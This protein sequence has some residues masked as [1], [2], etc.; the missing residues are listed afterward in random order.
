ML[1]ALGL[2]LFGLGKASLW[3]DEAFSVFLSGMSL[4]Q[5]TYRTGLDVHPPFYYYLLKVWRFVSGSSVWNLRLMSVFFSLASLILVYFLAR[6]LKLKYGLI[7]A[8]LTAISLA[9]FQIQYAQE[10]RMYSLGLFLVL[11][12]VYLLIRLL[13]NFSWPILT[14]YAITIALACYTHYYLFFLIAAQGLIVLIWRRWKILLSY[15]LAGLIF[16]PWLPTF[17]AQNQQ[18]SAN[19]WI[20]NPGWGAVPSTL[21]HLIVG[22]NFHLSQKPIFFA[23]LIISALGL[24][25][26]GLIKTKNKFKWLLLSLVATPFALSL[27]LSLRRSIFLDRY[28][29]FVQP[30]FYLL[31]FMG[32]WKVCFWGSSLSF[33]GL[34][35]ESSLLKCILVIIF[36]TVNIW[37]LTIYYQSLPTNNSE[38]MQPAADYI[39]KVW[40]TDDQIFVGS[41]FV[42]LTFKYYNQTK[43]PPLLYAPGE[44]LHFSGTAL[45]DPQDTI[46]KWPSQPQSGKN[47]WLINTTGFGNWQPE[48]PKTW[49]LVNQKSWPMSSVSGKIIISQYK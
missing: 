48:T 3:H 16:L 1:I 43:A 25:V 44:L 47:I 32:I 31:I 34:T 23:L 29:I 49:H 7:L 24:I 40:Q 45:I 46:K 8:S 12:S 38:G 33:P 37:G 30:F 11:L 19:Y 36:L 9:P 21:L 5:L 27:L 18:V 17:W 35:E 39:N 2:R 26:W 20:P 42:F 13:K 10:M 22:S 15:A 6:Q 28:F 14:L 4:S 41:S